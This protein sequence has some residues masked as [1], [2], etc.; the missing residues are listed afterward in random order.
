MGFELLYTRSDLRASSIH[1]LYSCHGFICTSRH[2][3]EMKRLS[4]D[5]NLPSQP[6]FLHRFANYLTLPQTSFSH[7]AQL[8]NDKIGNMAF[9]TSLAI[10]LA[11]IVSLVFSAS[12]NHVTARAISPDNTCGT[13][14]TGGSADSYVC[15]ASLP[16]CSVNGFCGSDNTYCLTTAGCQAAF[17]NCT[18]PTSGTTTPD[19]TCGITGAGGLGYTCST[20]KPCCSGK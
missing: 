2:D 18:A 15:P 8:Q 14:G 16:C 19:F 7:S 5:C 12:L 17:G 1:Y 4:S 20:D 6:F 3:K 10:I 13:N 11:C 9:S